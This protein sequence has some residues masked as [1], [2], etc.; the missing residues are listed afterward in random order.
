MPNISTCYQQR[1]EQITSPAPPMPISIST[2]GLERADRSGAH[3]LCPASG[4]DF[5]SPS[6]SSTLSISSF[7]SSSTLSDG[8]LPLSPLPSPSAK[9]TAAFFGSPFGSTASS[10]HLPPTRIDL[11]PPPSSSASDTTPGA[12]HPNPADATPTP[13]DRDKDKPR[14]LTAAFFASPTRSVPPSR[15]SSPPR[16]ALDPAPPPRS[17]YP[18]L[19]RL[20]PS[21]YTRQAPALDTSSPVLRGFADREGDRD[22]ASHPR[23]AVT[24]T[25]ANGLYFDFRSPASANGEDLER[26][27]TRRIVS[28]PLARQPTP[29]PR[30]STSIASPATQDHAQLPPAPFTTSPTSAEFVASTSASGHSH[31]PHESEHYI[32]H[33]E[34]DP[35]ADGV[36]I[37]PGTVI[38]DLKG[39]TRLTLVSA[40]GQ[41]AFSTVWLARG[42]IVPGPDDPPPGT[43]RSTPGS[44]PGSIRRSKRRRVVEGT[45]PSLL[46][47]NLRLGERLE[48]KK[49]GM[50]RREGRQCLCERDGE[51][52]SASVSVGEFGE[53]GAAADEDEDE[54]KGERLVAVKL[55]DRTAPDVND[56]TRISFVREVEVLRHISH[57][58]IVTYLLSFSTPTHYVLGLEHVG[59]GELFD[60]VESDAKHAALDERL[61]RR[62]WGELCKAV[63]WM[64]GVG[65]VH[66]DI[67]LENILLTC[68]PFDSG[69]PELP[70][71][72]I[73]L[74]DF[75]LARFI[76]PA[77]PTLS[78]R[79]GSESYAAPEL[80]LGRRYDGR[81]TDAWACGVV[82][83]ALACR[84]LPFEGE[85]G[86][87]R[88]REGDGGVRKE[89]RRAFLMRI[90]RGE[91]E[92][93]EEEEEEEDAE[94]ESPTAEH[95]HDTVLDA[96]DE[97][98]RGTALARSSGVRRVVDRLLVR[99]P[100]KRAR[101]VDLWD[102][103]WMRGEGAPAPPAAWLAGGSVSRR[104]S[105]KSAAS[106]ASSVRSWY[107][108]TGP[109]EGLPNGD[110]DATSA[111][112]AD[113]LE[114]ESGEGDR[115]DVVSAEDGVLMDA[116]AIDSVA[117]QELQ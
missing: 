23:A 35:D 103:E 77:E 29:L 14:S 36:E 116:E 63:G 98:L 18:P 105:A 113:M 1:H 13:T 82:L 22:H 87:G 102:E 75:G 99:D 83:Y 39:D 117:L 21:R 9:K 109:V 47:L 20:F 111:E 11:P 31:E 84:R 12:H 40:L 30:E 37:E 72:L 114:N 86:H 7:S 80:V 90:A 115:E 45:K 81:R 50:G 25:S 68:N 58:S 112:I 57:P 76:D 46:G 17:A 24:P 78:T 108:G 43:G 95:G 59:G 38:S 64:H 101:M 8:P 93:P 60:V 79:C 27:S 3:Q 66:R 61:L 19:H 62:I 92:W 96:E 69:A 44:R 52:A 15:E 89:G 88:G 33:E 91:Y 71:P 28:A 107:R 65:L 49:E 100:E 74:T 55:V 73:K 2:A 51:G 5:L 56:R 110:G 53:L 16:F 10:P 94:P 97:V 41:G 42:K 4:S 48:G 67:K 32:H 26:L 104:G 85:D 34:H 54:G 70:A 6:S 106:R